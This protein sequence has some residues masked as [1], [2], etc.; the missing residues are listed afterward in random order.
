MPLEP[1][2]PKYDEENA[3]KTATPEPWEPGF[4]AGKQPWEMGAPPPP[5]PNPY[6]ERNEQASGMERFASGALTSVKERALGLGQLAME[7]VGATDNDI[8]RSTQ[9]LA[10]TYDQQQEGTGAMGFAGEMLG[11]PLTY[12]PVGILS[13]AAKAAK[14]VPGFTK[15]AAKELA[16]A[17]GVTGLIAGGTAP[18]QEGE[19]RLSNTLATGAQSALLAPALGV[20][21]P[22]MLKAVGKGT[23]NAARGAVARGRD[24]LAPAIEALGDKATNSFVKM[25]EE[26]LMF[27]RPR[28]QAFLNNT[29]KA[30]ESQGELVRGIDDSAMGV[31][32]AVLKRAETGQPIS[33]DDL[34]KWRRKIAAGIRTARK[35]GRD[36]DAGVLSKT[37]DTMDTMINDTAPIDVIGGRTKAI[38][39]LNRGKAEWSQYKKFEAISDLVE[40]AAGNPDKLKKGA[41]R[42]LKKTG[43]QGYSEQE[44]TALKE[45][46]DS[47]MGDKALAGLSRFGL[48]ASWGQNVGAGIGAGV[49]IGAGGLSTA[50]TLVG[51][52]TLA[53]LLRTGIER[54]KAEQLLKIIEAGGKLP[55]KEVMKLPPKVAKFI[56]QNDLVLRAEAKAVEGND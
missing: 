5:A 25:R 33:L 41:A 38:E 6:K 34:Y 54:G 40:D 51:A 48:G 55:E 36:S 35:A 4:D 43:G 44:L 15:Q 52:G 23:V 39:L 17:G 32:E 24:D 1:W 8:Y 46:A 28:T 26:G 50:G 10:K 21:A 11:D 18:T 9:D 27:S 20:A 7:S 42:L 53:K 30:L 3:A 22:A 2:D 56:L 29:V 37:L 12:A 13:A 19:D 45:M 16:K 47:G 31:R 14:F 49:G